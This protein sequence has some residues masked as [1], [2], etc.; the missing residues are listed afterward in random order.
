MGKKNKKNKNKSPKKSKAAKEAVP[1]GYMAMGVMRG[2]GYDQVVDKEDKIIT[3]I[4]AEMTGGSYKDAEGVEQ[5][6]KGGKWLRIMNTGKGSS[7]F[8]TV[9]DVD[10]NVERIKQ[11]DDVF[12]M[13]ALVG[14]ESTEA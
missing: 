6:A 11:A 2:K 4:K 14:G 13:N 7:V 9:E 1:T 12:L 3:R 5:K 8:H 10:K